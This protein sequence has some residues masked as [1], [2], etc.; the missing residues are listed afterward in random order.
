VIVLPIASMASL[1]IGILSSIHEFKAAL[2]EWGCLILWIGP[3]GDE[4]LF[5]ECLNGGGIAR[6]IHAH[7]EVL[8]VS[9][10]RKCSG[11]HINSPWW[12]WQLFPL[13][14]SEEG[15]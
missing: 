10:A 9:K 1:P 5:T 6:L 4:V 14:P 2:T 11:S 3:E 15:E 8:G 12:R 7:H 13:S